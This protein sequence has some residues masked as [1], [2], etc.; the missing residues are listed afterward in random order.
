[1][2]YTFFVYFF[3]GS[4]K[5]QMPKNYKSFGAFM[6]FLCGCGLNFLLEMLREFVCC[7]FADIFL[8]FSTD[9]NDTFFLRSLIQK[10]V[11]QPRFY[12]IPFCNMK[13]RIVTRRVRSLNWR[14]LANLL[15]EFRLDIYLPANENRPRRL[16]L[17]FWS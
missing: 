1:M 7:F 2:F 9:G 15:C 3:L 16:F 11:P 17:F 12:D 5:N 4:K 10:G 14:P 8:C 13:F 6:M